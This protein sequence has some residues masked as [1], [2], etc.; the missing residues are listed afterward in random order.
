MEIFEFC[1]RFK[2]ERP[3][4]TEELMR[5]SGLSLQ[6]IRTRIK[7]LEICTINHKFYSVSDCN[8]LLN[9]D[10]YIENWLIEDFFPLKKVAEM[11][12][13]EPSTISKYLKKYKIPYRFQKILPWGAVWISKSNYEKLDEIV[14]KEIAEKR[15]SRTKAKKTLSAEMLKKFEEHQLVKDKRCFDLNYWPDPNPTCFEAWEA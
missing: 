6:G 8:K 9:S 4:T 2:I 10:I 12:C 14:E 15:E 11:C 13:V 5:M 1:P 7:K 3:M